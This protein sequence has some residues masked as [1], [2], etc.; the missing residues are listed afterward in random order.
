MPQVQLFDYATFDDEKVKITK[1]GY[2]IASP[3]VA[4]M[5]IQEYLGEEV[6]RPDL[7]IVR[8]Y[9]PEK[10][11]FDKAALRSLAHKPLTNGHPDTFVNADNWK[12]HAIG[13]VGDEFLRDGEFIRVPIKLMDGEAIKQVRAGK[14]QLS[15][16]YTSDILWEAGKTQ[17]GQDYDAIQE[18][19][20]ANHVALCDRAR[21]GPMLSIGDSHFTG[22]RQMNGPNQVALQQYVIDGVTVEMPPLAIQLVQ[23]ELAKMKDSL[24]TTTADKTKLEGQIA[25]LTT[26]LATSEG[27]IKNKDAEIATLTKQV[28]DGKLKPEDLDKLLQERGHVSMKAQA[29]LGDA[30]VFTGKSDNEIRRMVV[31]KH[32]GDIAKG[33][34]DE[35]VRIS[36]ETITKDIKP[37]QRL[38]AGGAGGGA[39]PFVQGATNDAVAA[40]QQISEHFRVMMQ[41]RPALADSNKAYDEYVQRIG[42]AY[43]A[44][45]QGINPQPAKAN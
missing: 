18:N 42:N 11:V 39:A 14:V 22:E 32:L 15:V 29:Y 31:D 2:L 40:A 34:N 3:R 35:Q 25:E 43:Q 7:E 45:A 27:T 20:R 1:D 26:K 30:A 9:R 10:T 8:I 24:A 38:V 44:G 5:G 23:K 12:Q 37:G 6:G 19:I 36:F 4:R 41:G 17:D 33:W 16:G 13:D 21:G 28:S